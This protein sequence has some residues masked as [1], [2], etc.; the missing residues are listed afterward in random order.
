MTAQELAK[1]LYGD[2]PFRPFRLRLSDGRS[3]DI[4]YPWLL[5]V[6][7]GWLVIGIPAPDEP[8]FGDRQEWVPLKL[9]EGTDP[10]PQTS[11]VS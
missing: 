7:E 2:R 10:L 11:T 1:K 4:S 9:V 6:T 3:F 8:R 5:L